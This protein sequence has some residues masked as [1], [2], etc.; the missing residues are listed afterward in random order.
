M[1]TVKLTNIRSPSGTWTSSRRVAGHRG[2]ESASSWA[3]P[4]AQVHPVEA[5]RPGLEESPA[6]TSSSTGSVERR[7]AAEAR[8]RH[9][10]QSYALYP[11]MSVADN[12]GSV[13]S[14]ATLA[15]RSGTRR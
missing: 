9:G 2:R 15:K 4:A 7:S 5:H 1:A 3:R 14:W 8:A 10:V 13:S 12:R 6:A 11:H